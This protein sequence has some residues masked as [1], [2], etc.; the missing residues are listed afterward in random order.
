[1]GYNEVGRNK[2]S[3]VADVAYA[4]RSVSIENVAKFEL[5]SGYMIVIT[6]VCEIAVNV[7]RSIG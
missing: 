3:A 5:I 7:C 1:V 6:E 2:R 4:R